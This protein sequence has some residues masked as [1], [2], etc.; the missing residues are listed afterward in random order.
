MAIPETQL[1]TWSHQGSVQQSK[2]TY[3][4]IKSVLDST[5]SPYY[6]K[7]F[8]S[9]LQGSYGNDTNVYADSD[10]DTVIRLDSIYYEDRSGM[11]PVE[12]AAAD[13]SFVPASYNLPDFKREV[14]AWLSAQSNFGA[15]VT[16]GPKAIHIAARGNRRSA[17]VLVS[18]QLRKYTTNVPYHEGVCFFLANG[19]RVDNFP[20]QHSQNCTTKHQATNQWFKPTVRVFKNMRNRMIADGVIQ[21]GVAPSY[22]IEGML[23]N[24]PND[25]FG[26]SFSN[27]VVSCFNWIV[28]ADQ[29]RFVCANALQWLVRDLSATSWP[30]AS[31]ALFLRRLLEYWSQW[32]A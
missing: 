15:A 27:T 26:V 16:L 13:A 21:G 12:L 14:V 9:F 20:K 32:R 2:A 25:K 17:D 6:L 1:A 8:E 31:Y 22:F 28:N 24:V 18:A 23:Y 4:T 3:G 11:S 19:T 30:T 7:A 5:S 10:V 29:S